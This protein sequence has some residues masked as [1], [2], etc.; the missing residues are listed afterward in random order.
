[1]SVSTLKKRDVSNERKKSLF[2]CHGQNIQGVEKNE[3]RG[4]IKTRVKRKKDGNFI[5]YQH[6]AP[7]KAIYTNYFI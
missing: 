1:M 6:Q 5:E 3:T 4:K 7:Y 2:C